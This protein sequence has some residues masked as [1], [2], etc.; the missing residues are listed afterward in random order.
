MITPLRLAILLAALAIS[1]PAQ[2][3]G[4]RLPDAE[5]PEGGPGPT[6]RLADGTPDLGNGAGAWNPNTVV[7]LAGNGRQGRRRSPGTQEIEIPYLP[8]AK[9]EFD[10]RNDNLGIDDPEARCLPPGI[11]RMNATPFPFQIYQVPGKVIFLYEGGTHIWRIIPIDGREHPEDP[12]PTYLG[13]ATGHWEG[14][15][16][17][18]DVVGFNLRTWLD[19]DG[20]PH[21]EELHVIERYTRTDEMT[22]L[23]EITIDDPGAYSEPWSNSYTIPWVPG[24]ELME[25]VCQE[26][27]LD[28]PHLVG[29]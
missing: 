3:P 4:G 28:I 5:I 7:N 14:D 2:V 13:D 18:V 26:N 24:G 8:W 17:V 6:P 25:Y 29:K 12:N 20:N 16:L 10:R 9:A 1:M 19:Q 15:T 27:N 21:T 22:L 23:Y 11:P